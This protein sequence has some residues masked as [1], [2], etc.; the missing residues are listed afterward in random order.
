DGRSDIYALGCMLYCCLT[1]RP[2]FI[3]DTLLA[4]LQAKEAGKFPPVRRL[5]TEVPKRLELIVDKM[6]AREVRYRY[7]TCAEVLKDLESLGRASA[8]LSFIPSQGG[9]AGSA[10]SGEAVVDAT[11][12]TSSSPPPEA[13]SGDLWY[14]CYRTPHGQSVTR[15]MTTPQVL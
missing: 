2:P 5:N 4:L 7:Q 14:V 11:K 10:D 9:G 1:G 6:I 12:S 8:A 13:A 3:G 15:K